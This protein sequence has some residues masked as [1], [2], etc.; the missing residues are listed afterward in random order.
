MI[1]LWNRAI[2]HDQEQPSPCIFSVEIIA[3][4]TADD[5]VSVTQ[6]E[7]SEDHYVQ[8]ERRINSLKS[9][10]DE[11]EKELYTTAQ[12]LQEALSTSAASDITVKQ[13]EEAVQRYTST[14]HPGIRLG[15]H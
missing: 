6:L 14:C 7:E 4:N 9:S 10:L 5:G 3:N 8:A 2:S 11:R 1:I 15:F 12:K 13:L